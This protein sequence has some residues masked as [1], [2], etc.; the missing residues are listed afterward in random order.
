MSIPPLPPKLLLVAVN[1]VLPSM[2]MV[3]IGT[4]GLETA[5][6]VILRR[7]ASSPT[8]SVPNTLPGKVVVVVVKLCVE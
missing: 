7:G 3:G 6:L 1:A 5:G 2:S 4:L 8:C